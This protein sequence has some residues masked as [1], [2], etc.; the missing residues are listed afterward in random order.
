MKSCVLAIKSRREF[1]IGE[2]EK[3]KLLKFIWNIEAPSKVQISIW[4]LVLDKSPAR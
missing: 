4:R 3:L 2:D 1:S